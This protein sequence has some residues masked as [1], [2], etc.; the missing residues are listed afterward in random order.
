MF[1]PVA[2]PM[3]QFKLP[4]NCSPFKILS[5][6]PAGALGLDNQDIRE[7]VGFKRLLLDKSVYTL[8]CPDFVSF[9]GDY[10]NNDNTIRINPMNVR[11]VN[12]E[13]CI[14]MNY[15][16]IRM[17]LDFNAISDTEYP[18]IIKILEK[19]FKCRMQP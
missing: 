3:K 12:I 1:S 15:G 14:G 5:V 6:L 18:N 19:H 16:T 17:E 10:E 9:I 2:L 13:N 11:T 8:S 7:P 4:D